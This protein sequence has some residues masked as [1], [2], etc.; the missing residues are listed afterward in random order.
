MK[1]LLPSMLFIA[2]CALSGCDQS[3]T[4]P[5]SSIAPAAPTQSASAP[6]QNSA[7]AESNVSEARLLDDLRS[8]DFDRVIRTMN[9]VK[10]ARYAGHL[11]PLLVG[12]WNG[13]D[14]RGI[15]PNFLNHPR[16]R[17]EIADVLAQQEKNG[18]QG[19]D[20]AAF[21]QYA[22]GLITSN[23]T[24]VAN[25]AMLVLGIAG[26]AANMSLLEGM[27]EDIAESR[28]RAA[29]IGLAHNCNTTSALLD[30]LQARLNETWRKDFLAETREKF[31][32]FRVCPSR[33]AG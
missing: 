31:G 2:S 11:T 4:A 1:N 3:S 28:F 25:Q 7:P 9:D 5:P 33:S 12:F 20:K 10:G 29:V 23:D 30:K 27:A 17:I 13:T 32:P 24:Q 21:A 26:S 22:R 18:Y 8:Q 16:V 6:A 15:D 14:L 19:L